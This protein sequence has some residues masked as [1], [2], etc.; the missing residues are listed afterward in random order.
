VL[1]VTDE[2]VLFPPIESE[3]MHSDFPHVGS[4]A[5]IK[6]KRSSVRRPIDM[7]DADGGAAGDP[8]ASLAEHWW[9][10]VCKRVRRAVVFVDEP[11]AE[12][13]HWRGGLLRL[14]D[15]AGASGVRELSS[16]ESCGEGVKKAS[17]LVSGPV[18]GLTEDM[19]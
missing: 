14:L 7:E 4:N 3:Q 13:L 6:R 2:Q 17:F 19:L 8:V 18:V 1:A 16:F 10:E 15:Q 11:A 12:A 5:M 9:R